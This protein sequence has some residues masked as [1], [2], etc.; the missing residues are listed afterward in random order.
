MEEVESV[1]EEPEE[2]YE[3]EAEYYRQEVGVAPDPGR[4]VSLY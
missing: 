4:H 3:D 1:G 2:D